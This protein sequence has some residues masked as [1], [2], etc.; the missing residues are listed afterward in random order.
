LFV[1][2]FALCFIFGNRV[3]GGSL[4]AIYGGHG[5]FELT[6]LDT[7]TGQKGPI[8][9][10]SMNYSLALPLTQ[11]AWDSVNSMLYLPT[12]GPSGLVALNC[13]NLSNI[14]QTSFISLPHTPANVY[15]DSTT[16]EILAMWLNNYNLVD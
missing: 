16:N 7:T 2:S 5:G 12:T 13:G 14:Q 9:F 10:L 8:L 3:E 15:Y 1:F 11:V 6:V 4:L